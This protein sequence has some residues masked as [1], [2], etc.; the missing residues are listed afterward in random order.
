MDFDWFLIW[1]GNAYSEYS[2]KQTTQKTLLIT[3]VQTTVFPID[4]YKFYHDQ[5]VASTQN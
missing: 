5:N 3:K 4:T 2:I 1:T